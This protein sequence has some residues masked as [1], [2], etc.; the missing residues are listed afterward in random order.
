MTKTEIKQI[1]KTKI[2]TQNLNI[3]KY[4]NSKAT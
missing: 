3:N 2:K 4:Y 1:I